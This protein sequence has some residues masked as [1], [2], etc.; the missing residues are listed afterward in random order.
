MKAFVSG[1]LL[2]CTV[3][4]LAKA[5]LSCKSACAKDYF[6]CTQAYHCIERFDDMDR[7]LEYCNERSAECEKACE[8][9]DILRGEK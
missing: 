2:V 6:A 4:Y 8:V 3:L 1:L 5:N 7:C 9:N